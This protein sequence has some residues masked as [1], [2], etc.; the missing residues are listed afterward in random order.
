MLVTYF[1]HKT[2]RVPGTG[3]TATVT[4]VDAT[5]DVKLLDNVSLTE[6]TS[7]WGSYVYNY[8]LNTEIDY[9]AYFSCTDSNY[10]PSIDKLY[11]PKQVWGYLW[12]SSS[13]YDFNATDRD[14]I[15]KILEA[16]Q[17]DKE[18]D[19][20]DISTKLEE[21]SQK[22]DSIK[23]PEN[24]YE[25]KE[26]K[27]AVKLIDSVA[28]E[29]KAYIESEKKEKDEIM[30]IA[31]ELNKLDMEEA[32]SEKEKEMEHKKKMEEEKKEEELEMKRIEQL[33]NDEFDKLEEEDRIE[34]KKE[35]ES[36]LKEK[37]KELNEIKKELK[38]L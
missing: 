3:L 12:G 5:N 32:M 9:I 36:E 35:L 28:K 18:I 4:L 27:K 14:N 20:S 31:N 23:I 8:N 17:K 25:E 6:L 13:Q 16:L 34:K 24:T 38:S 19:F 11:I 26:A 7:M 21:I 2:T 29:L 1:Y 37:E 30:A 33:L 15:Y 10:L 22:I